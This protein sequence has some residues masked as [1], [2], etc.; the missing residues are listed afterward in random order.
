MFG[1]FMPKTKLP[2][3]SRPSSVAPMAFNLVQMVD[4][5]VEV[6]TNSV[7]GKLT[8]TAPRHGVLVSIAVDEGV[9]RL[10]CS[11]ER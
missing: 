11:T 10:G 6:I 3:M 9:R 2:C 7:C 4:T 8:A 5:I 1:L